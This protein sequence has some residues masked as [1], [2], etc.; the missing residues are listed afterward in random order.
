MRAE[1][2]SSLKMHTSDPQSR[3]V[4]VSPLKLPL[5]MSEQGFASARSSALASTSRSAMKTSIHEVMIHVRELSFEQR[6]NHLDT[7]FKWIG[8]VARLKY[9]SHSRGRIRPNEVEIVEVHD[10]RCNMLMPEWGIEGHLDKAHNGV[11][12]VLHKVGPGRGHSLWYLIA[13]VPKKDWVAVEI[14]YDEKVAVYEGVYVRTTLDFFQ[15][16]IA[17]TN[18][19]R[20]LWS[21]IVMCPPDATLHFYFEGHGT[22]GTVARYRRVDGRWRNRKRKKMNRLKVGK[23]EGVDDSPWAAFHNSHKAEKVV[24]QVKEDNIN[25]IKLWE[26]KIPTLPFGK[27]LD[28]LFQ[29]DWREVQLNDVVPDPQERRDIRDV[30]LTHW[31]ALQQIFRG[32][33]CG[34]QPIHVMDQNAFSRMI[35]GL[36]IYT[37]HFSVSHVSQIFVRVNIEE[38]YGSDEEAVG[39]DLKTGMNMLDDDDN[40]DNAFI[41]S[42]YLEALVRVAIVKWPKK[43]PSEAFRELVEKHILVR[44]KRQ[45]DE[46]VEIRDLMDDI[47]VK[48]AFAPCLQRI[49]EWVFLPV[50]MLDE[51]CKAAKNRREDVDDASLSLEELFSFHNELGLV[52]DH[53]LK[54]REAFKAYAMPIEPH[55]VDGEEDTEMQWPHFLEMLV[56]IA[57]AM[58]SHNDKPKAVGEFLKSFI[59]KK[60]IVRG[61]RK[62]KRSRT[63][64]LA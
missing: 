23:K 18:R 50:T 59:G 62:F 36:K 15:E 60:G 14:F 20:N 39:V 49:F 22:K 56:R 40:P 6:L 1:S 47:K 5:G 44:E 41:R 9:V 21:T 51:E 25:D 63:Q 43:K 52:K 16:P 29:K 61:K 28:L 3:P 27:D 11:W 19:S 48:Q 46:Y 2:F 17:L 54:V 30:M 12:V 26:Y 55:V 53:G 35:G 8:N 34:R 57:L 42:E 32:Y 4:G 58:S 10:Y 31:I 13:T 37:K 33:C 7:D 45:L 38:D 24:V 64:K